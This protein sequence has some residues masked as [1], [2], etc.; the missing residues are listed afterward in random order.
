V[1][2]PIIRISTGYFETLGLSLL[3]G[4]PF[5][6]ADSLQVQA[7]AIVNLLFAERYFAGR[8]PIG[9]QI[10][11]GSVREAEAAGSEP[12]N[13]PMW[14]TVVG[15]S[16]TVR[17][18]IASGP[19][20]VVY[21]PQ[22]SAHDSAT[23]VI[24]RTSFASANTIAAFRARVAELDE[25]A[26]LVNV[27]PLADTLRN[28]RLQPQLVSTVLGSL[29]AVALFLSCVGL[30]AITSHAVRQRTAEIGLRLALGGTPLQIVW[31][32]MRRALTPIAAGLLVGLTGAF[33]VG[34]LLRG[35]LI[36]TSATDPT[37]SSDRVRA[38]DPGS[39]KRRREAGH[40][41]TEIGRWPWQ[42][43]TRPNT[44]RGRSPRGAPASI[45]L[46]TLD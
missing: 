32:C 39:E 17:Q 15:V 6:P 7:A 25:A 35:P 40:R 2:A 4:R 42:P 34:Q 43:G 46:W 36:G 26:V 28:S 41:P 1:N 30:Y 12:A 22:L 31:L 20:P 13:K 23:Q 44:G 16:P 27:R 11:V 3:R 29:S 38:D 5:E 37:C 18:A 45:A 24:V 21:V 19:R 33:G 8:D 10:Q 14:L 9:Q